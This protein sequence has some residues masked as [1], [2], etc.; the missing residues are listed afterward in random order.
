MERTDGRSIGEVI[1]V[2]A[3]GAIIGGI[4]A[5]RFGISFPIGVIIAV[6]VGGLSGYFLYQP[7]Q[8]VAGVRQ[9]FLAG[10]AQLSDL[11]WDEVRVKSWAVA[12]PCLTVLAVFVSLAAWVFLLNWLRRINQHLVFQ[13]GREE[14]NFFGIIFWLVAM[15]VAIE[16]EKSADRNP[17][18]GPW[19]RRASWRDLNPV[20]VAIWIV[21]GC[22]RTV[23]AIWRKA[24]KIDDWGPKL[25]LAIRIF[26]ITFFRLV[27]SRKRGICAFSA[28]SGAVVGFTAHNLGSG[29]IVAVVMATSIL[30]VSAWAM[31]FQLP[32]LVTDNGG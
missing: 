16:R 6:V 25:W 7:R 18:A 24:K 21:Y 27:H 4:A 1:V 5:M 23:R 22:F 15:L 17:D 10:W 3:A 29:V 14:C 32:E 2:S 28:A 31:R 20:A 26:A 9:A 12:V 30:L 11:T 8:A 13:M 19:F